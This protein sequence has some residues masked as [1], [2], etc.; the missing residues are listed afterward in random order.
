[1]TKKSRCPFHAYSKWNWHGIPEYEHPNLINSY[2]LGLQLH[3]KA[4]NSRISLYSM[5]HSMRYN[6]IDL[7]LP[8]N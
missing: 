2:E 1:M 3:E 5:E 4:I 6:Q 8:I 7:F